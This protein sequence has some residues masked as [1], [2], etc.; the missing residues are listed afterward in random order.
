MY[1]SM[2]VCRYRI[3]DSL[4]KRAAVVQEGDDT[5]VAPG[6]SKG[7]GWAELV[8]RPQGELAA[9]SSHGIIYQQQKKYLVQNTISTTVFATLYLDIWLLGPSGQEVLNLRRPSKSE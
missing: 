9:K 6:L 3:M 8:L 2:D 7:L 4:E 1:S 5:L